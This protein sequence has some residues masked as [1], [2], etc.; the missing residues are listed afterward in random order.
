[1]ILRWTTNKALQKKII[2][3]VSIGLIVAAL[4]YE[5]YRRP[6]AKATDPRYLVFKRN[7]PE[8]IPLH[9]RDLGLSEGTD[10]TPNDAMTDQDL[11]WLKGAILMKPKKM[12]E[13]LRFS[14]LS[15]APEMVG[16]SSQIPKGFRAYA[17]N[18]MSA[19][20]LRRNDSIDI[21]LSPKS[22]LEKAMLL[23]EKIKVLETL[24][25]DRPSFRQFPIERQI[26]VA[27]PWENVELLE[28][29]KQKGKLSVTLR[30]PEE[31]LDKS[32]KKRNSLQHGGG[33]KGVEIWV[34]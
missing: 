17:I 24:G 25:A 18:V 4:G 2:L 5:F 1:M 9:F 34:H 12:G 31:I 11:P 20:P 26:V 33:V 32:K 13:V 19:I 27:I 10:T 8:G 28:K 7:M 16:L 21:H 14:D 22:P 30:H 6:E 23:V 29:A 15:L 3:Y